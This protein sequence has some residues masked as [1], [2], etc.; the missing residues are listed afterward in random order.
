[1]ELGRPDHE[2][3][4]IVDVA[5]VLPA[6]RAAIAAHRTQLSP[7]DGLSPDLERVFLTRDHFVRLV[8][9]WPGGPVETGLFDP[10]P[11]PG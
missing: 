1:M 4:T 8:P 9:P 5:D 11:P 10:I 6:R 2:V 7:L 3:T